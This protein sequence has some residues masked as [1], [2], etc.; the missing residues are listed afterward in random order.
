MPV[1]KPWAFV[2]YAMLNDRISLRPFSSHMYN[3]WC[4]SSSPVNQPPMFGSSHEISAPEAS[5]VQRRGT[6]PSKTEFKSSNKSAV[7]TTVPSMAMARAF[8]L[9]RTMAM[10]HCKRC[11]SWNKKMFNGAPK[12][13][14]GSRGGPGKRSIFARNSSST[15]SGGI[16]DIRSK[17]CSFTSSSVDFP[18]P[19]PASLGWVSMIVVN[20]SDASLSLYVKSA[21]GCKPK[22]MGEST[23]GMV[24]MAH[25]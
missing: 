1:R 10:M 14:S 3:C 18:A 12:P 20:I 15:K 6:R 17:A 4:R 16:F 8:K 25:L 7:M 5:W 13:L 23:A 9:E 19:E 2:K 21:L 11:N 24:S 22:I